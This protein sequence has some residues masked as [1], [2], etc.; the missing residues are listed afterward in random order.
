MIKKMQ[1]QKLQKIWMKI[2]LFTKNYT[3]E[4]NVII[5][6]KMENIMVK[7][8]LFR[9]ILVMKKVMPLYLMVVK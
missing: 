4:Q 1:K 7:H 3:K 8:F 6:P 5:R 2:Q 9:S